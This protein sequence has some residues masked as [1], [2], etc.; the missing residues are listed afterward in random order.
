M[1]G[2]ERRYGKN[3]LSMRNCIK[4]LIEV[5]LDLQCAELNLILVCDITNFG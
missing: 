1:G 5:S 3:R 4:Y 2:R